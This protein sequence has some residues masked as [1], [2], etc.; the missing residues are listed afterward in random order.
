[1]KYQNDKLLKKRV[2]EDFDSVS[3]IPITKEY[4]RAEFQI[5]LLYNKKGCIRKV[6]IYPRQQKDAKEYFEINANAESFH[7]GNFKTKEPHIWLFYYCNE[8]KATAMRVYVPDKATQFK[9][10]I[11]SSVTINFDKG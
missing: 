1:M 4:G 3:F 2:L 10:S 11:G 5:E 8:H 7:I 6:L 9:I